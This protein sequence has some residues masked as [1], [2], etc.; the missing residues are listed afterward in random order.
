MSKS[1]INKNIDYI[2]ILIQDKI[3]LAKIKEI[4][5]RKRINKRNKI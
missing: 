4:R 5:Y 1:I 3:E 2:R